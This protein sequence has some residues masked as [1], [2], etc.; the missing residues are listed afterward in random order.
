MND[1]ENA[2][3][4]KIVIADSDCVC[5]VALEFAR[6]CLQRCK[7]VGERNQRLCVFFVHCLCHGRLGRGQQA[8]SRGASEVRTDVRDLCVRTCTTSQDE[9]V[10]KYPEKRAHLVVSLQ[11]S[12]LSQA[13]VCA[14]LARRSQ[15]RLCPARLRQPP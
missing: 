13:P 10:A 14:P 3:D 9:R 2:R 12:K 6:F 15:S 1:L 4:P 8:D 7:T 5:W 11:R